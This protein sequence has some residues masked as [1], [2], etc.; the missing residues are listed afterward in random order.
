MQRRS[1]RLLVGLASCGLLACEPAPNSPTDTE[2]RDASTSA[3]DDESDLDA[4]NYELSISDLEALRD[5]LAQQSKPVER[6]PLPRSH[7]GSFPDVNDAVCK[8]LLRDEV[9][10]RTCSPEVWCALVE[11]EPKARA[12]ISL[13]VA[14][15]DERGCVLAYA[16]ALG[17]EATEFAFGE[18]VWFEATLETAKPLLELDVVTYVSID[19]PSTEGGLS[20]S[21]YCATIPVE[22]CETDIR[23]SPY[24]AARF[25]AQHSCY[26]NVRVGCGTLSRGCTEFATFGLG[27]DG[28]CYLFNNGC[29]PRGFTEGHGEDAP[30]GD[31]SHNYPAC[32][33]K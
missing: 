15:F 7:D 17:I 20:C 6:P 3:A 12:F 27:P 23:C 13:S 32:P 8:A 5:Y 14:G 29:Q 2:E 25:D 10:E 31:L 18:A 16:A 21:D 30:C 4:G 9:P 26:D 19:C 22:A 11:K 33:A 24:D 28:K 1:L